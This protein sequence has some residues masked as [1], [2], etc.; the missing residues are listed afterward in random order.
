MNPLDLMD[1]EPWPDSIEE[2][3]SLGGWQNENSDPLADIIAARDAILAQGQYRMQ[4]P[5]L[6]TH[7]WHAHVEAYNKAKEQAQAV[8][9]SALTQSINAMQRTLKI[10]ATEM[11]RQWSQ[12][13]PTPPFVAAP[14][15]NHH[16]N[17]SR[18][19]QNR[20]RKKG[21]R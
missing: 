1:C 16:N 7:I 2:F 21:K 15:H 11:A 19:K 17:A 20:R 10:G 13:A 8:D 4:Q 6:N 3:D 5:E 18:K 14:K 12:L 9:F